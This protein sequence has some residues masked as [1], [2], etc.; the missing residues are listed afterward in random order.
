MK[1]QEQV[2]FKLED[3]LDASVHK[4]QQKEAEMALVAP[5]LQLKLDD[6][7]D[8][9]KQLQEDLGN[10]LA[11]GPVDPMVSSSSEIKEL[12][13][14][15]QKWR[16]QA[17]F[18]QTRVEEVEGVLEEV[19]RQWGQS[20][21]KMQIQLKE[22]EMQ[23]QC[24]GFGSVANMK[25]GAKGASMVPSQPLSRE[26]MNP[27]VLPGAQ[28]SAA[29]F[30]SGLASKPSSSGNRSQ[31]SWKSGD[32]KP[33][34]SAGSQ[35]ATRRS[36]AGSAK[37]GSLDPLPRGGSAGPR[38][39]PVSEVWENP[40]NAAAAESRGSTGARG[41]AEQM[42]D[43]YAGNM[44][45]GKPPSRESGSGSANGRPAPTPPAS[46]G[47]GSSGKARQHTQVSGAAAEDGGP[48][49]SGAK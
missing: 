18:L 4:Q 43:A 40:G 47:R 20:M 16:V 11:A 25:L 48:W 13:R 23:I 41:V 33:L 34:G 5:D 37:S 19:P 39:N 38:D 32:D 8:V 21:A 49:F 17:Q 26:Q 1:D 2:I 30:M 14:E 3:L 10:A 28:T 22:Q 31:L 45:A 15:V 29:D 35:T 46:G 27:S 36:S 12:E 6:A 42:S 44:A 24:G 7:G 9:I